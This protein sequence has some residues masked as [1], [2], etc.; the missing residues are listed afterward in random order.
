MGLTDWMIRQAKRR[1]NRFHPVLADLVRPERRAYCLAENSER[2]A[3]RGK[4]LRSELETLR[5]AR[6]LLEFAPQP[7]KSELDLAKSEF[8]SKKFARKSLKF[9]LQIL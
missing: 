5:F 3:V 9:T 8:K 4:P 1:V 2:L 6:E 7:A